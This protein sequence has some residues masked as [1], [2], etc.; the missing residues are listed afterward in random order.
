[1][2][3]DLKAAERKPSAP[4]VPHAPEDA[5]NRVIIPGMLRHRVSRAN[6][7]RDELLLTLDRLVM[8][9]IDAAEAT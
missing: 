6:E 5:P 3:G 9:D 1:M 7:M 8:L 4:L 2:S